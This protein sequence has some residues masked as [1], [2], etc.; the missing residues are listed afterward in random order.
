MKDFE[1]KLQGD[2]L[3]IIV[4]LTRATTNESAELKNLLIEQI[5]LKKRKIIV[6]LKQC[7]HM[8]STFIGVL[9]LSH[10]D[11]LT[12]GGELKSVNPIEPAKSI[13][14]L[15]GIDRVL[16]TYDT[17]E[18]AVKSFNGNVAH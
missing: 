15:T 11:L 14:K 12:K 6:D 10:R 16:K 18:E 8:D 17:I 2:V 4:N 7:S 9:V 1:V 13:L 5:A 3:I